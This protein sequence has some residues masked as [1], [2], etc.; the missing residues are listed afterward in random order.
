MSKYLNGN[1]LLS[2]IQSGMNGSF[3]ILSGLYKDGLT[4]ANLTQ[5]MGNADFLKA[6]GGMGS[7]F[8]NYLTQ[9]FGSV[10]KNMDGTIAADEMQTMMTQ[11]A[12]QGLTRDQITKLGGMSGLSQD[13]QASVLDHFTEI[14]TNKDGKV[15]AGEIQAFNLTSKMENRKIEDE[16][17]MIKNSSIFYANEDKEF[18]SSLVSYKW[19][20]E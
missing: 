5:A 14:D 11:M 17:K 15:S 8:A 18:S 20:N 12:N 7:T 9:N 1:S 19:L 3:S 4:Q 10:D 13:T 16:N 6:T 2:G